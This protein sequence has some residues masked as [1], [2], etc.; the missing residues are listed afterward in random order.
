M[1]MMQISPEQG[2]FMA[3]CSVMGARRYL[4]IGSSPVIQPACALRCRRRTL[5]ALDVS[6]V[7]RHRRA[8]GRRPVSPTG[9]TCASA[10]RSIR[11][12][13]CCATRRGQFDVAFI[14]ADK[15]NY[16]AYYNAACALVRRGGLIMLD[17][18]FHYG[19]MAIRSAPTTKR[20]VG[21]A[22][23]ADPGR[24]ARR[25]RAAH[26]GDGLTLARKR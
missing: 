16:P 13:C 26:I 21:P 1:A 23:P 18:M 3:C 10:R 8:T 2:A 14:D 9:S 25:R 11:W 15:E 24:R 5:T 17:N 4:E 12:T 20:V 22:E 19:K 7:D 6:S